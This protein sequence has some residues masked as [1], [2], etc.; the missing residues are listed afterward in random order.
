ME[1]E[2]INENTVKFYISYVDIEDRGFEREEIWYNRERSEQ[3]FWQMMDEVNYKEDFSVEGPLWIQVQALEK[4]LEIIVTKAQLGKGDSPFESF[5][6][7]EDTFDITINDKA[8]S[9]IEEKL[10]KHQQMDN[11]ENMD[12]DSLWMVSTFEE[13][14]DVIQLSHNI[15]TL[16][17]F[18]IRTVLYHY[19]GK[20]HL[21]VEIPEELYDE[22]EDILSQILEFSQEADYTPHI[23]E[24]YG[25]VV[26]END[27][28]RNV[29]QYFEP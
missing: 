4:G 10:A 13:L 24:E 22:Q 5:D 20:Y 26:F 2:R 16:F 23:L 7:I 19:E 29:R 15:S 3:L 9:Y 21:Y 8:R 6:E 17:E 1:I 14:E 27:V 28:F 12:E 25:V 18:D 11:K